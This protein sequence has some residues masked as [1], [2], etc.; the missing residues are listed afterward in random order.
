MPGG[1]R[2]NASSWPRVP[3]PR[4]APGALPAAHRPAPR[5]HH[6]GRFSR[7]LGLPAPERTWRR[8]GL[9]RRET[10]A[11]LIGIAHVMERE[12]PDLVVVLGDENSTLAACGRGQARSP[13][14]VE[15]AFATGPCARTQPDP[16]RPSVGCGSGRRPGHRPAGGAE[17]TPV[18]RTV[19][20]C[21]SSGRSGT[22]SPAAREPVGLL[23]VGLGQVLHDPRPEEGAHRRPPC[24]QHPGQPGLRPLAAG[25]HVE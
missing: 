3:R 1:D 6:V 9:P 8:P 18:G 15:A 12:R 21:A 2:P 16:D 17:A 5:R 13:C 25:G 19:P 10:A 4:E 23:E 22:S 7:D 20:A 11:V 24:G 14:H